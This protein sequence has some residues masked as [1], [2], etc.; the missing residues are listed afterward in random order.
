MVLRPISPR[1][2]TWLVW[3]AVILLFL[4][5]FAKERLRVALLSLITFHLHLLCDLAGSRGPSKEDLWPIFYFGP[6][7]RE[8]IWLW[9]GQWPLYAWPNR[10]L[11]AG[12]FL[13]SL[14]VAV[15]CGHSFVGVFNRRADAVFVGVLRGWRDSWH[16]NKVHRPDR[17]GITGL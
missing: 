10:L 6:F 14:L 13:W 3:A 17:G 9:K 4:T 11:T 1:L 5:P 8:P 15:Q 12:L 7:S 16:R 2:D